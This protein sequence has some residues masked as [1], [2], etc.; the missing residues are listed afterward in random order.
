MNHVP[1]S[2]TLRPVD[3]T[4]DAALITGWVT[5]ERAAFW[6]MGEAERGGRARDLRLHRRAGAP[7][8]VPPG[9]RR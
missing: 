5:E 9:A 4:A 2:T 1:R 8:G 6:G 3:P 7:R